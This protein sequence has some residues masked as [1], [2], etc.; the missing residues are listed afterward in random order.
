MTNYNP[1]PY[2][3]VPVPN[4]EPTTPDIWGVYPENAMLRQQIEKNEELL[5]ALMKTI[6]EQSH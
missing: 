1:L 5:D 3:C 4:S 6:A 2:E